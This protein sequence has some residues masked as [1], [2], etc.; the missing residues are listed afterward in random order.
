M[1]LKLVG[2]VDEQLSITLVSDMY[3]CID[4]II[5]PEAINPSPLYWRLIDEATSLITVG[6][7]RKTGILYS[8]TVIYSG[9]VKQG[10]DERTTPLDIYPGL[11]QFSTQLWRLPSSLYDIGADYV[12]VNGQPLFSMC[13]SGLNITLFEDSPHFASVHNRQLTCQF[14]NKKELCGFIFGRDILNQTGNTNFFLGMV[15]K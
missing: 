4:L 12:D 9:P 1:K 2:L 6:V 14:N 15:Q 5:G 10:E 13:T 8:V 11:P 3:V 7:N